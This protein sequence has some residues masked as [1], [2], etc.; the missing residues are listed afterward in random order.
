MGNSRDRSSGAFGCRRPRSAAKR[1]N[2][3]Y[4]PTAA[5]VQGM[6]APPIGSAPPRRGDRNASDQILSPGGV[7]KYLAS[8]SVWLR[9]SVF[10]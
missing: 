1:G 10:R 2:G 8:S 6:P 9:V 5:P 3:E 7:V 4:L